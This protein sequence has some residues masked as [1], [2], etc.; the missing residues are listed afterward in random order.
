M[1]GT[2][3]CAACARGDNSLFFS[4]SLFSVRATTTRYYLYAHILAEVLFLSITR[5]V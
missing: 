1:R 2:P 3:A 5:L 4:L